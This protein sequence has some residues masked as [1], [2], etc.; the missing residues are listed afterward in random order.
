MYL[1]DTSTNGT[2]I[3]GT[4]VR[5]G[6]IKIG[7]N[8]EKELSQGDEIEVLNLKQAGGCKEDIIGFIYVPLVDLNPVN[9]K[10]LI[11]KEVGKRVEE[12]KKKEAIKL[13]DMA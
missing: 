6:N 2:F 9:V 11:D 4:K 3:N 1:K 5:I 12:E 7:K 13:D 8:K 10:E